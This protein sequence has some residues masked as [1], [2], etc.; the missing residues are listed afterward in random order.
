MGMVVQILKDI[1][2]KFQL[3]QGRKA[4]YRPGWD[5]HGLPIE[6]KVKYICLGEICHASRP[7][8]AHVSLL[9]G[10]VQLNDHDAEEC[11]SAACITG[12][13]GT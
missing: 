10:F 8:F 5:C 13:L 3:L 11:H 2:V 9:S 4:T 1:I 7:L 12:R 6:L